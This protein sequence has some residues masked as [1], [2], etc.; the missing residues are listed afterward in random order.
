MKTSVKAAVLLG[1]SAVI[2]ASLSASIT[3]SIVE[4]Q[5]GVDVTYSGTLDLTGTSVA[6]SS[7]TNSNTWLRPGNG[8]VWNMVSAY[9]R[10]TGIMTNSLVF[11]TDTSGSGGPT[12]RSGDSFGIYGTN[13]DVP[14]G[15]TSGTISGAMFFQNRTL[16][17]LGISYGLNVNTTLSGSSDLIILTTSAAV[18]EPSTYAAIFGLLA[19]CAVWHRRR[20]RA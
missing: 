8:Q 7:S 9:D 16:A 20:V 19:L 6:S 12:N 1:L 3:I 10:Y 18:P 17:D 15:F 5:T 4:S 11:G 2:A 14:S 13:L